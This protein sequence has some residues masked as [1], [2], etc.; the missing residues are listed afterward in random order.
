MA[1]F[2]VRMQ[3]TSNFGK[4]AGRSRTRIFWGNTLRVLFILAVFMLMTI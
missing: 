4:Q 1:E 2:G 3:N